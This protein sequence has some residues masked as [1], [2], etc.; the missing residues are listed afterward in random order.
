MN[1]EFTF[2]EFRPPEYS[3]DAFVKIPYMYEQEQKIREPFDK[4]IAVIQKDF[5]KIAAELKEVE[6]KLNSPTG[7]WEFWCLRRKLKSL[8]HQFD[9]LND[10]LN[11]LHTARFIAT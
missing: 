3:H 6:A 4:R 2:D 8:C 11:T 1:K 9:I 10:L 5:F 7:L